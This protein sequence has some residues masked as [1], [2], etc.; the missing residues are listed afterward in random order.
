L[1][2]SD[3]REAEITVRGGGI[4]GLAAA[5]ALAR[6]GARVRVVEVAHLGAGASGGV[7][8][9]LTPHVPEAWNSKKAFQLASLLMAQDWWDGVAR[10]SGM[11]TGYGRIGRVQALPD[12]GAVA[13]AR[14]R[15]I[16]A[17]DLWQGKAEW[18]VIPA[19]GAAWEPVS[20]TGLLAHDTLSAR[21][22]PRLALPALAAAI[23]A[24]GGEIMEQDAKDQGIVLWANG[25]PGLLSL[26]QSTGRNLA[27][28][29]K[30]QAA[31]LRADGAG[32]AQIYAEGLHIV[33][34][35]GSLVAVGST[36]EQV[37]ADPTS[38]DALLDTVIARARAVL[39][40]LRDAPVI[41]RWA[42][43]R[44]RAASRAPIAGPWPGRPGHFVLNGGFKI[45]F[46]MAPLL[47]ER[48]ADLIVTG[49]A[50]IPAE[51]SVQAAMD[52]AKPLVV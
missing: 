23:R 33:P 37:W 28:A 10:A 21:I 24:M 8:G 18:Q 30:G 52:K 31:L 13:Q 45:G 17:Q 49:S 14:A 46:G 34:H 3:Q 22:Y 32:R 5:W 11:P 25:V 9:A 4:F 19:T 2:R 7:V 42:G 20:P 15:A 27:G 1:A 48:M 16:G 35:D 26:S 41:E 51:F 29:V 39:P 47:A 12:A 36:S 44:P 38:T 43:L 50:D 40:A 6:R